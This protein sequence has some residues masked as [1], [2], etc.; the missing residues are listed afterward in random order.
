MK[1]ADQARF[2]N[3]YQP[4]LNEL[5]LQGK[6]E[7]TIDCYSRCVRQISQFFDICPDKITTEQLKVYFL[8]LVEN[9]SWSA[10]K[11]TRNA[12]QFFFKHVLKRPWEW[13]NIV[14]PPK[15]QTIQDVLSVSV[16]SVSEVEAIINATRQLRH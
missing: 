9:K 8:N 11:I 3:L 2:D 4:Y 6:S 13:V 15:Q 7:K 5:T 1:P 10:V 14:K 16:L 12:I